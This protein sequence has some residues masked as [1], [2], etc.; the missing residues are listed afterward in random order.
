M[1]EPGWMM[2]AAH[3]QDLHTSNIPKI[4]KTPCVAGRVPGSARSIPEPSPVS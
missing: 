3:Y 2:N 4:A 1:K